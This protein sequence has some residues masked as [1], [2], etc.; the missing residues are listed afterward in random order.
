M[1]AGIFFLVSLLLFVGFLFLTKYEA[2]AGTRVLAPSRASLDERTE[3]LF[4]A[5][6]HIDASALIMHGIR[7]VL[8][9]VVHDIAHLLL[10][11]V[12]ALQK[13]LRRTVVRLKEKTPL[14]R[15]NPR[16]FI[17]HMK[18]AKKEYREEERVE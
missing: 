4:T 16:A 17:E 3:F 11:T 8:K 12:E 13:F 7:D 9:K 1:I 14:H 10:A 6:K 5:F 2:R 18:S 15:G